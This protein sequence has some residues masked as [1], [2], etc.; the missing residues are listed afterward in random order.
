[1]KVTKKK[2]L[3]DSLSPRELEIAY[4]MYLGMRVKDISKLLGIK[5]N[6]ISTIKKNLFYKLEIKNIIELFKLVTEQ[7]IGKYI[8]EKK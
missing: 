5:S 7:N 8:F 1:M 4:Y 3:L 2:N 6:T